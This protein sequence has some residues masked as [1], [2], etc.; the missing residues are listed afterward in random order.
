MGGR[1]LQ[2]A[3]WVRGGGGGGVGELDVMQGLV[4]A[5]FSLKLLACSSFRRP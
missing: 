1:D 4:D 3:I 5:T 2:G